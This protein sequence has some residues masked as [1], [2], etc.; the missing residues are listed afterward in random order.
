MT[1]TDI[2]L[3]FTAIGAIGAFFSLRQS[4]VSGVRQYETRYEDRYWKIL[5][6]LT[7]DTLRIARKNPNPE[8]DVNSHD[9]KAIRGYINLCEDELEQRAGGYIT[10]ITYREWRDGILQQFNNNSAFSKIWEDTVN[11]AA[12]PYNHL[13]KLLDKNGQAYDPL[14]MSNYKK[15]VRGLIGIGKALKGGPRAFAFPAHSG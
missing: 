12:F 6:Q 4:Y 8:V 13:E 3:I 5:D 1:A 11:E 2:S 14:N 15:F 10:D 7:L 9:E